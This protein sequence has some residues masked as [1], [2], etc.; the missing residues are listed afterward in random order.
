[1]S[2][3]VSVRAAAPAAAVAPVVAAPGQQG[4]PEVVGNLV[5]IAGTVVLLLIV[6]AMGAFAY[7]SL[8]GGVDWPDEDE[9]DDDGL[10][11]GNADDEWDYY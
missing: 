9:Q 1:M 8:T 4:I 7:K 2:R 6:V 11:Q 10:T 3:A 5:G